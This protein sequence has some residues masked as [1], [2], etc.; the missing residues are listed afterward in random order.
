M[1]PNVPIRSLYFFRRL[2]DE[3][4]H[5]RQFAA[6][7]RGVFENGRRCNACEGCEGASPGGRKPGRFRVVFRDADFDGTMFARDPFHR[8]G[9]FGDHAGWPSVSINSNASQFSGSP[10]FA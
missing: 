4:D 6:W 3:T 10:I 5:L 9:L 7:H 8:G 2:L 1:W